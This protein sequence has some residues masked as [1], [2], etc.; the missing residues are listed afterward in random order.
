MTKEGQPDPL[1]LT[2]IHINFVDAVVTLEAQNGRKA[3]LSFA[4]AAT[5]LSPASDTPEELA[6]PGESGWPEQD[7]ALQESHEKQQTVTLSGRL[8]TKPKG[9]HPDRQGRPT[10]W[11]QLAVQEEGADQAHLY[12]ATFYR[13]TAAIAL[14]L[15][16]GAEVTVAGYP[17]AGDPASKRLDALAILV[18]HQYPGKPTKQAGKGVT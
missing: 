13:A 9:G 18:L 14:G 7:P 8:R 5:T 16:R 3:R 12:S 2:G 17:R 6:A 11:A 10:A 4:S 15:P 1:R